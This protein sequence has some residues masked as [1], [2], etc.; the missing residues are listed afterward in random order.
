MRLR[1]CSGIKSIQVLDNHLG[2]SKQEQ[3][4]ALSWMENRMK[5]WNERDLSKQQFFQ[6]LIQQIMQKDCLLFQIC[7]LSL[8]TMGNFASIS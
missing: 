7:N 8:F 4:A 5:K 6:S 2:K 1:S 3:D